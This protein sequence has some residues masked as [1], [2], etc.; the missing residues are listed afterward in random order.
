M[1]DPFYRHMDLSSNGTIG[2]VYHSVRR[3]PHKL[4]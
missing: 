1:V 2:G 3:D 4:K